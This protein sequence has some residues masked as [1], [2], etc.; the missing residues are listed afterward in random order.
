MD[1]TSPLVWDACVTDWDVCASRRICVSIGEWLRTPTA[2]YKFAIFRKSLVQILRHYIC[3]GESHREDS[4]P[5]DRG[6]ITQ[7]SKFTFVRGFFPLVFLVKKRA[8][9]LQYDRDLCGTVRQL[10][11]G[12]EGQY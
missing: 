10:T 12:W 9:K 7:H 2:A 4:A 6:L 11:I 3:F 8:Q 5:L 1:R